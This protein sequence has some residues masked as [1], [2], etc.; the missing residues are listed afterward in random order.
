VEVKVVVDV[1]LSRWRTSEVFSSS[2]DP[3]ITEWIV[4]TGGNLLVKLLVVQNLVPKLSCRFRHW[5]I[6]YLD[7]KLVYPD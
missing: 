2:H 5:S 7:G 6:L 1:V 4:V 3:E